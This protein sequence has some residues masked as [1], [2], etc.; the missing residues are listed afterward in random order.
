MLSKAFLGSVLQS[1]LLVSHSHPQFS[2]RQLVE[3]GVQTRPDPP[4]HALGE[5]TL[6][7]NG[8]L[9]TLQTTPQSAQTPDRFPRTS[10]FAGTRFDPGTGRGF[11]RALLGFLLAVASS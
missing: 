1:D 2:R 3:V 4:A 5:L 10:S 11:V 6:R 9:A 8:A 7:G